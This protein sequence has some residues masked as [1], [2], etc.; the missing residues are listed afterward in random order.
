MHDGRNIAAHESAAR[1]GR[2]LDRIEFEIGTACP[3]ASDDTYTQAE[4]CR[5]AL[6]GLD[7]KT[8][9]KVI[10][11]QIEGHEVAPDAG[12]SRG[13]HHLV[14]DKHFPGIY[15]A[16]VLGRNEE[17]IAAA[18]AAF[19]RIHMAVSEEERRAAR[20]WME[21]MT[22]NGQTCLAAGTRAGP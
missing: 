7:R 2:E 13:E 1:I 21:S 14:V 16:I 22:A 12:S 10:A 11:E 19:G 17:N 3:P 9:A 5:I 20:G 8:P 4:I 15:R 6:T 18:E